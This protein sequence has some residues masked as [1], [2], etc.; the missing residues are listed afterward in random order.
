MEVF[1]AMEK[2][3]SE[4]K[5][6]LQQVRDTENHIIKACKKASQYVPGSKTH[7]RLL[8]EESELRQLLTSQ[9]KELVEQ[10]EAFNQEIDRLLLPYRGGE[11]SS[12][13]Q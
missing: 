4:I 9:K 13:Q 12:N 3:N 11:H 1:K 8:E 6:L 2:Q 10:I 5:K 7:N